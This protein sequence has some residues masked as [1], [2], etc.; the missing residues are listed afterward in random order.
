MLFRSPTS[1]LV[2]DNNIVRRQNCCA[3][4]NPSI[5]VRQLEFRADKTSIVEHRCP[6]R[7]MSVDII[8]RLVRPMLV[9]RIRLS[10][11]ASCRQCRRPQGAGL[12][13]RCPPTVVIVA[14]STDC[15][16]GRSRQRL[17]IER[18]TYRTPRQL[19]PLVT[20]KGRIPESVVFLG[21]HRQLLD[22]P[23]RTVCRLDNFQ[24]GR[25]IDS[26]AAGALAV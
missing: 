5:H 10:R 8:V 16:R 17:T 1:Y 19:C 2:D 14:L 20:E 13:T 15:P 3:V 11:S 6:C 25:S 12:L 18:Q 22:C 21:Q 4:D 7:Q 23:R 9:C 24:R 26:T